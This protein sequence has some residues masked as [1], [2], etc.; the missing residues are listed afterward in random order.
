MLLALQTEN[1]RDLVDQH[2]V[3]P[4]I[5]VERERVVVRLQCTTPAPGDNQCRNA[6]Y[7]G[8]SLAPKPKPAGTGKPTTP[9]QTSAG[10]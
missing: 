3:S 2:F 10:G 6:V 5:F 4:I 8:G 7:V 9:P 1:F